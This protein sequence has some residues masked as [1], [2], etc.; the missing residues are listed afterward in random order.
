MARGLRLA[1]RLLTVFGGT[2]ALLVA[3]GALLRSNAAVRPM[4]TGPNAIALARAQLTRAQAATAAAKQEIAQL[5]A[6]T[7]QTTQNA[8]ALAQFLGQAGI[9]ALDGGARGG[10]FAGG[11]PH[12]RQRGD[13]GGRF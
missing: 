4:W 13:D 5:Q 9:S 6:R 3:G 10:G 7:Q 8:N 2:G 1:A 11:Y 12:F